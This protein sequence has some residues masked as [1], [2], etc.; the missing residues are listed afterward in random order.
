[1]F[2]VISF[3][4]YGTLLLVAPQI[5]KIAPLLRSNYSEEWNK[6]FWPRFSEG[7][8]KF[9]HDLQLKPLDEFVNARSVYQFAFKSTGLVREIEIPIEDAIELI[10]KAHAEAEALQGSKELIETL[11]SHYP[12]VA[13]V[14]DADNDFL[15]HALN[16]NHLSFD[17]IVSSESVRAYK[18]DRNGGVF[19]YLRKIPQINQ[20]D[21]LHIGDSIFDIIGAQKQGFS[22]WLFNPMDE[23]L[24]L[25][26]PNCRQ[27][28]SLKE[29]ENLLI[30]SN[31]D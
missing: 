28:K 6:E 19:G 24:P 30:P 16:K 7:I 5:E 12:I 31:E 23:K 21:I 18:P 2:K 17:L 3:D 20:E 13:L 14:S 27:V 9:Y 11:R 25:D 1:M 29:I 4:A 26:M 22:A 15:N 10:V 8:F